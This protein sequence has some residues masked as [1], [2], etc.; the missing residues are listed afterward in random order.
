MYVQKCTFFGYKLHWL[1][2]AG[3]YLLILMGIMLI[4]RWIKPTEAVYVQ[5]DTGEVNLTF[6]KGAKASGIGIILLVVGMYW[7]L[8]R[9]F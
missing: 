3:I 8:N 4:V 6:W 1:H 9:F 5:K 2:L 7:I